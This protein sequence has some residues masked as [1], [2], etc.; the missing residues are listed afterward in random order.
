MSLEF[1]HDSDNN[2]LIIKIK[3]LVNLEELKTAFS[4]VFSNNDIPLDINTLY[5]LQD[6]DFSNINAEFEKR[7]ILFRESLNRGNAKIACVVAS[8]V[9]YGMGRMYKTLS[10]HLPQELHIFR[11]IDEAKNWLK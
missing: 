10:E 4:N 1:T 11:S 9:G 7:L 3:D 6:M 8:D 2:I 5:D